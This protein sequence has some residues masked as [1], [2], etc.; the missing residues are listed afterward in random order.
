MRAAFFLLVKMP[1]TC[2]MAYVSC[3]KILLPQMYQPCHSNLPCPGYCADLLMFL[4]YLRVFVHLIVQ[5]L[6]HDTLSRL[7]DRQIA[8]VA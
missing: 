2:V 4:S 3:Q 6:E 8:C 1:H 5:R 7:A